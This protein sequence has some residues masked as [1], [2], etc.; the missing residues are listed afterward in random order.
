MSHC[1]S[2]YSHDWVIR[3]QIDTHTR[4]FDAVAALSRRL[5]M[6]DNTLMVR[7]RNL[8]RQ[9]MKHENMPMV[10]TE[11]LMCLRPL[12]EQKLSTP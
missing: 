3:Q 8:S 10:R 4:A 5:V 9:L 11:N 1:C 6:Q 12:A 2:E 7:T